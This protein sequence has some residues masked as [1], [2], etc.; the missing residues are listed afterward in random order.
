MLAY[1]I[2]LAPYGWHRMTDAELDTNFKRGGLTYEK[3]GRW[4]PPGTQA[5]CA[6]CGHF[7]ILAFRGTEADDPED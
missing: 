3:I 5:V 7:A 1:A 6:S 4:D 2:W